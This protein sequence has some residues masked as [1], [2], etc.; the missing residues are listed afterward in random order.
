MGDGRAEWRVLSVD[1]HS[2]VEEIRHQV[3][4]AAKTVRTKKGEPTIIARGLLGHGTTMWQNFLARIQLSEA[5]ATERL[6]SGQL[7]FYDRMLEVWSDN[8]LVFDGASNAS[9]AIR[10]DSSYQIGPGTLL[11][12]TVST[13]MLMYE[14]E[15]IRSLI[16]VLDDTDDA[17]V[18]IMLNHPLKGAVECVKGKRPLPLRYGGPIDLPSWKDGRETE[19]NEDAWDDAGENNEMYEGFVDYQNGIETDFLTMDDID[20]KAFD[21]DEDADD[22]VDDSLFIWIHRDV[23]LGARGQENGGGTRLGTS[24]VWLIHE[25]DAVES[26]QSG[27]LSLQDIMVFSGVC[28]WEKGHDLGICGGGMREQVD[29]LHSFEIVQAFD[30]G[31]SSTGFDTSDHEAIENVWDILSNYQTILEKESLAGNIDAAIAAWDSCNAAV[32]SRC[33]MTSQRR[34]ITT[35]RNAGLSDAA[36][37]AWV[38]VNLLMDP[39]GT[40]VEVEDN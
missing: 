7:D 40:L 16:L 23:A 25:N 12:G 13:D 27:L 11:R 1:D 28:I 5:T 32:D 22:D 29:A 21:A 24:D 4:A 30:D 17:T 38:G 34:S 10:A 6:P 31:D 36:L 35:N 19:E 20:A 26:L 18:G 39:L 37:R 2:I 33:T 15:F 9:K 8:N 14:Q 3:L